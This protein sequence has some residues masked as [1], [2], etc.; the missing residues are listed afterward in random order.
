MFINEGH[1]YFAS[2]R[3]QNEENMAIFK[4]YSDLNKTEK[5]KLNYLTIK[6]MIM[7]ILENGNLASVLKIGIGNFDYAIKYFDLESELNGLRTS[8]Y[9]VFRYPASYDQ[10]YV[11]TDFFVHYYNVDKELFRVFLNFCLNK[12]LG[13]DIR[14]RKYYCKEI[15][16]YLN[17]LG[18]N[19]DGELLRPTTST[20]IITEKI[21]STIEEKLNKIDPTLLEIRKGAIEALL[22]NKTDKERAVASSCRALINTL[23]R[24]LVPDEIK[25]KTIREKLTTI[26]P[27]FDEES[28]LI[29]NLVT[30][31][32]TLNEIQA[33][34]DHAFIKEE[35][36]LFIFEITEKIIYFIL[37]HKK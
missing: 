10:T 30:T 24:E 2:P 19:Y 31:I 37:T 18:Y 15:S 16:E 3:A 20:P 14:N 36:A 34:G 8:H 22:S 23:L 32:Q 21:T 25:K 29:N 4:K 12:G 26:L 1:I 11:L 27:E 5:E 6:R 13:P 28:E 9:N 35:T 17:A 33:K 7:R